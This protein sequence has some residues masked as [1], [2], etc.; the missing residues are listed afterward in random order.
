MSYLERIRACN[1]HDASLYRDFAVAGCVVG[2][3][4][5]E[6]ARQLRAWPD[7]F[8]VGTQTV[9]LSAKIERDTVDVAERSQCVGHVLQELGSSGVIEGWRD[10]VHKIS[11]CW[12]DAPLLLVERAA[13]PYFGAGGVAVHLN[14]FVRRGQDLYL[15][16]ARRSDTKPTAPGKLDHLVAGG[17]PANL[18]LF[19]NLVKECDEEAGLSRHMAERA[20]STGF[21]SYGY[22]SRKGYRPDVIYTFDLELP[23]SF[24]PVNRDGEVASFTLHPVDEVASMV[25]ETHDFKRNCA[26]VI[27]DFLVRHGVVSAEHPDYYEIVSALRT[28]S[29]FVNVESL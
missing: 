23:D 13:I 6:F 14:G 20:I 2:R 27:I 10:E 18:G 5:H 7:V 11:R 8:N 26:L 1:Q 29:V 24:V 15:W 9:G 17:Q 4:T 25:R 28:P 12:S 22:D 19:E 3:M 16:V 21:V